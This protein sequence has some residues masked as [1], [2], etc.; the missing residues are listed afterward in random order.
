MR[1][2]LYKSIGYI[3]RGLLRGL[4]RKP[5]PPPALML[6]IEQYFE[7]DVQFENPALVEGAAAVMAAAGWVLDIFPEV[8]DFGENTAAVYGTVSGFTSVNGGMLPY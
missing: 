7:A 3:K 5:A 6:D 8:V 4:E 1:R 2:G